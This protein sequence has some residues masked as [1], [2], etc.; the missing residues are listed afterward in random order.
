M[1]FFIKLKNHFLFAPPRVL[2]TFFPSGCVTGNA[3]KDYRL[4]F[5]Y[6]FT[7]TILRYIRAI[8]KQRKLKSLVKFSQ[9]LFCKIIHF[10][11]IS[12]NRFLLINQYDALL[13]HNFMYPI[14]QVGTISLLQVISQ[15]LSFLRECIIRSLHCA[16][17]QSKC[18]SEYDVQHETL[19]QSAET[20]PGKKKH[21]ET[22]HRN[23]K[24]TY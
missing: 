21:K 3:T 12:T 20:Y 1:T 18:T 22:I 14:V 11:S 8:F 16:N 7:F 23:K 4:K 24:Q 17:I 9:Q 15:Q 5:N 6:L 10:P 13:T 19:E 2:M